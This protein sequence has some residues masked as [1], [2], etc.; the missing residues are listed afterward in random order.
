MEKQPNMYD[1]VYALSE[2][3]HRVR[4]VFEPNYNLV[5]SDLAII[6][7]DGKTKEFQFLGETQLLSKVKSY[8]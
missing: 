7:I 2:R 3:I 8:L 5:G 6:T 1:K 4:L